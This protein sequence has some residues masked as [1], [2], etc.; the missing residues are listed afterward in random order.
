MYMISYFSFNKHAKIKNG[1]NFY[2]LR[3][4]FRMK[5]NKYI[6]DRNINIHYI[7]TDKFKTNSIN[8]FIHT[9]LD[10]STVTLNALLPMVLK[11]GS[12][13][14]PTMQD[15][16]RKLE[17]LY[18]SLFDARVFKIGER[19]IIHFYIDCVND[20]F[21]PNDS[22]FE[23]GI[24]V[25]NSIIC[26]PLIEGN[27][28]NVQYIQQEKENL[29][30][31][32]ESRI[33]DKVQYA[34][35]RCYEL[36]CSDERYG[37]HEWGRIEDLDRIDNTELVNHYWNLINKSRIDIIAIGNF[38]EKQL[39]K[40]EQTID[41]KTDN[42]NKIE[43]E[44][45]YKSVKEIRTFVEEMDVNQGKLSIGLRNNVGPKDPDYFA[46]IV[47]TS[48]LGGGP[49]SKL[50][51]NV[52]EKASLAYYAFARL[53]RMKGLTIISSGIE[54]ENYEKAKEIILKQIDEM[55]GGNVSVSEFEASIKTLEN[56]IRSMTDEP[57]QIADFFLT[58]SIMGS[59]YD[60]ESFI[61]KIKGVKLEEVFKVA[62]K[63]QLDTIHFI[64]PR[65]G[66]EM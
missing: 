37:I 33:N 29:K 28:F 3:R 52:R 54:A 55:K 25:L 19:Q 5:V 38:S 53:E 14:Y 64:K 24:E 34:I 61:D 20:K 7:R 45:V 40:L 58:Q 23:S 4:N 8:V 56:G 2:K 11:R 13:D 66:K 39:R 46:L 22:I 9:Q 41:L 51:Q 47:F 44:N 62:Q 36:M 35:E 60:F 26:R 57:L 65:K 18:G 16:S 32:I 43:P 42:S 50:F 31:R 12:M 59:D 15:L 63:V 21:L 48:I 1:V 17:D 49:H 30:N 6:T 27:R 10:R